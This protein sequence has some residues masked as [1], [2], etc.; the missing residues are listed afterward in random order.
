MSDVEM[1]VRFFRQLGSYTI[2]VIAIIVGL[3]CIGC[4]GRRFL[5]FYFKC[6][7]HKD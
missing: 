1:M 5:Q 2:L 3:L 7:F 6:L 4:A